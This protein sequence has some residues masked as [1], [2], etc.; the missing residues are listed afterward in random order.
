MKDQCQG[1]CVQQNTHTTSPKEVKEKDVVQHNYKSELFD[2]WA[3]IVTEVSVPNQ[4]IVTKGSNHKVSLPELD[5][6]GHIFVCC[7]NSALQ[8]SK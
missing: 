5:R 1:C 7:K 3:D 6:D 2:F 8:E 4:V